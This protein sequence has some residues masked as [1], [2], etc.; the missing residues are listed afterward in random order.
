[1]PTC[2]M[3]GTNLDRKVLQA[4]NTPAGGEDVPED[5]APKRSTKLWSRIGVPRASEPP[6]SRWWFPDQESVRR[7]H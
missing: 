4:L 2:T 6:A 5:V 3:C 1:M 7:T